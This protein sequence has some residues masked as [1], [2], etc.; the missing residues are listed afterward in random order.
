MSD[1]CVWC[2]SPI[3]PETLLCP[4]CAATVEREQEELYR[5]GIDGIPRLSAEERKAA[6]EDAEREGEDGPTEDDGRPD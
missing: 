3:P 6:V 4:E 5:Q 1:F 2:R